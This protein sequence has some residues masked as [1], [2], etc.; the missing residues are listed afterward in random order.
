MMALAS[1]GVFVAK[2]PA[3]PITLRMKRVAESLVP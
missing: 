2:Y 3:H 1:N